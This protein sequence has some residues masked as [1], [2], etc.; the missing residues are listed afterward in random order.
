MQS[1]SSLQDSWLITGE[2]RS[3][4]GPSR[5]MQAESDDVSTQFLTEDALAHAFITF[6]V[7]FTST[8]AIDF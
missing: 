4:N 8:S 1:D 3:C 2:E 6:S 5:Q 7:V